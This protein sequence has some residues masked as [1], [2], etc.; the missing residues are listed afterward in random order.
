MEVGVECSTE[1]RGVGV[2]RTSQPVAELAVLSDRLWDDLLELPVVVL[3]GEKQGAVDEEPQV[4]AEEH[5]VRDAGH[6]LPRK[7]GV[8]LR[9]HEILQRCAPKRLYH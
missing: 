4:P 9:F 3:H 5:E 2:G 7:T 6:L 8:D 1:L